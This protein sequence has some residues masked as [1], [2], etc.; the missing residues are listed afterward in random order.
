M[1]ALRVPMSSEGIAVEPQVFNGN[2]ITQHLAISF[3]GG[4]DKMMPTM[5]AYQLDVDDSFYIMRF[6]IIKAFPPGVEVNIAFIKVIGIYLVKPRCIIPLGDECKSGGGSK[7]PKKKST[8]TKKKMMQRRLNLLYSDVAESDASTYRE[9]LEKGVPPQTLGTPV[10]SV[11]QR[12]WPTMATKCPMAQM[13]TKRTASLCPWPRVDASCPRSALMKNPHEMRRS[14]RPFS[15]RCS[16]WEMMGMRREA[17]R[18]SALAVA[19]NSRW[20]SRP[21]RSLCLPPRDVS[22]AAG[23]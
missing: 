21:L 9:A 8:T 13:A 19:G 14:W 12:D 5:Q 4:S 17:T 3:S 15:G 20:N 23:C 2:L 7:A 1:T 22:R 10:P 6:P 18:S 11:A 16:T